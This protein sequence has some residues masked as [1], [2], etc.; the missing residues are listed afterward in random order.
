MIGGLGGLGRELD[1]F[2]GIIRHRYNLF[3]CTGFNNILIEIFAFIIS[4]VCAFGEFSPTY[5]GNIMD[6]WDKVTVIG[7]RQT[8]Q[9]QL[10]ST[11]A[12][13]QASRSGGQIISEKKTGLNQARGTE[14]SKIAKQDRLTDE[15]V[16][17]VNR[18]SG[19]VS[20]AIQD[21]RRLKNLT[22][23]DLATKINEKVSCAFITQ[24]NTTRS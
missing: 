15:G 20:K 10:K 18:V 5:L 12:L 23:K 4:F 11:F 19:S 2:L 8:T 14:G 6:D 3:C 7:K 16:F 24:H 13:N 9:K 21:G 17:E 22:Q 1:S